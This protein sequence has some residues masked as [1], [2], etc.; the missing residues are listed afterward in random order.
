MRA[1]AYNP[2]SVKPFYSD[3]GT[4][5]TLHIPPPV[6]RQDGSDNITYSSATLKGCITSNIGDASGL[7]NWG[8]IINDYGILWDSSANYY[9]SPNPLALDISNCDTSKNGTYDLRG[10]ETPQQSLGP[11]GEGNWCFEVNTG[12]VLTI[13]TDY[14][15]RPYARNPQ[16]GG[17]W[18]DLSNNYIKDP[19]GTYT[20]GEIGFFKTRG[21]NPEITTEHDPGIPAPNGTQYGFHATDISFNEATLHGHLISSGGGTIV[22]LG[23]VWNT[24]NN[25]KIDDYVNAGF[26]I[27]DGSG[28][29]TIPFG[30]NGY[31]ILNGSPDP[32]GQYYYRA[33]PEVPRPGGLE[34]SYGLEPGTTYYYAAFTRNTEPGYIYGDYLSFTTLS[35]DPSVNILGTANVGYTSAD[36]SGEVTWNPGSHPTFQD[37]TRHGFIW[38][39]SSNYWDSSWNSVRDNYFEYTHD[40]SH[41]LGLIGSSSLSSDGTTT[42][43]SG[44][45]GKYLYGN[46]ANNQIHATNGGV[47]IS[48]VAHHF[49]PSS[50]YVVSAFMGR[51]AATRQEVNAGIDFSYFYSPP[52][53]F[54]TSFLPKPYITFHDPSYSNIKSHDITLIGDISYN[55]G[56]WDGSGARVG[57]ENYVPGPSGG[58]IKQYGVVWDILDPSKQPTVHTF[59]DLGGIKLFDNSPY[60]IPF[61]SKDKTAVGYDPSGLSLQ[62]G[63]SRGPLQPLTDY[64]ARFFAMNPNIDISGGD[65]SSNSAGNITDE[66]GNMYSEVI[67]FTT[68][69]ELVIETL[70]ASDVKWDSATL[71]GRIAGNPVG[72]SQYGFVWDLSKNVPLDYIYDV[73]FGWYQINSN[74][75]KFWPDVGDSSFN[76]VPDVSG[77]PAAEHLFDYSPKDGPCSKCKSADDRRHP[78]SKFLHDIKEDV[79]IRKNILEQIPK[80]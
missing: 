13:D 14:V 11:D 10:D 55:L 72:L 57:A 15:F 44:Q 49:D 4:F 79:G 5:S 2:T 64:C 46:M 34:P 42:D 20:Y 22:Q 54:T 48:N 60:G 23:F 24:F 70:D 67:C 78:M 8:W 51:P 28:I 74:P 47:D 7:K 56:D 16:P 61:T 71:G 41:N 80:N 17:P 1:F 66:S 43:V 76:F 69:Q 58:L 18:S 12:S 31:D 65:A 73:S 30:T 59:S 62:L 77:I 32:S 52:I 25:F 38:D 75:I 27:V 19:S 33:G 63:S 9:A 40:G 37:T 50:S 53:T 45:F 29:K 39:L 6:S 21:T 68:P 26:S 3:Y 36:I 35:P